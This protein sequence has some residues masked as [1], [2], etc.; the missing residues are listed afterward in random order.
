MILDLSDPTGIGLFSRAARSQ[1]AKVKPNRPSTPSRNLS[2]QHSAPTVKK[3]L[4]NV[5]TFSRQE[6]RAQR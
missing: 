5:S 2:V 6:S 1:A 3:N 4:K